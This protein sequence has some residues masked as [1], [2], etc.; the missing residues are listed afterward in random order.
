LRKRGH[1]TLAKIEEA[2]DDQSKQPLKDQADLYEAGK[3]G[4]EEMC[5]KIGDLEGRTD[6]D[7]RVK[8]QLLRR[9]NAVGER[10]HW[11]ITT[12]EKDRNK[13]VKE[14]KRVGYDTRCAGPL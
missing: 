13:K 6:L 8:E 10:A 2:T 1:R 5:K 7:P 3:V 14:R 11:Q 4:K 9:E 12:L